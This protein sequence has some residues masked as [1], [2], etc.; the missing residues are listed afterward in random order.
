M[1]NLDTGQFLGPR[2][3]EEQPV[4][5][6]LNLF[7]QDHDFQPALLTK[8]GS[9]AKKILVSAEATRVTTE[10]LDVKRVT[11]IELAVKRRVETEY[12][13]SAPLHIIPSECIIVSISIFVPRE[14]F[15]V[16]VSKSNSFDAEEDKRCVYEDADDFQPMLETIDVANNAREGDASTKM[17]GLDNPI[18]L[19]SPKA[20]SFATPP[21]VSMVLIARTIL[22]SDFIKFYLKFVATLSFYTSAKY[23]SALAALPIILFCLITV[24]IVFILIFSKSVTVTTK[25]IASAVLPKILLFF[26]MEETAPYFAPFTALSIYY[27]TTTRFRSTLQ[28]FNEPELFLCKYVVAIRFICDVPLIDVNP[29]YFVVLFLPLTTIQLAM[30]ALERQKYVKFESCCSNLKIIV[31]ILSTR[32]Q[33]NSSESRWK[34]QALFVFCVKQPQNLTKNYY[35]LL[36]FEQEEL[37]GRI[38]M[39]N[40]RLA[41]FHILWEPLTNEENNIVA[42]NY[43]SYF[44]ERMLLFY[45]ETDRVIHNFD[46]RDIEI[47]GF[48]MHST[49]EILEALQIIIIIFSFALIQENISYVQY[50]DYG[51]NFRMYSHAELKIAT[52]FR[53]SLFENEIIRVVLG[54]IIVGNGNDF[55]IIEQFLYDTISAFDS[56]TKCVYLNAVLNDSQ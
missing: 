51:H 35:Y 20:L 1:S 22:L 27:S 16:I 52:H 45:D 28:K 42:F 30:N 50:M 54:F 44:V 23:I 41:A 24:M 29:L 7:S 56:L 15:L 14:C 34:T 9:R 17:E 38:E 33:F 2:R 55:L 6:A 39:Q 48:I 49:H 40:K 5:M 10:K 47:A 13:F 43:S 32:T 36:H 4:A 3:N 25:P 12:F 18:R 37:E 19:V 21:L 26:Q 53:K 46:K 11:E 8:S 31:I